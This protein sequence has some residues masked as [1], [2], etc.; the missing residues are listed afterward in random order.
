MR[1]TLALAAALVLGGCA[2]SAAAPRSA[3]LPSAEESV[4]LAEVPGFWT[5]EWGNLVLQPRG[6]EVWGAYTHRDGTLVGRFERGAI[7]GWWSE[8]P[9]REAS[10]D[11]GEVEIHFVRGADGLS[12]LGRYRH[13][14]QGPWI[15][16][17]NLRRSEVAPPPELE[18]RFAEPALFRSRP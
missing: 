12:L 5:G 16:V 18:A 17:W 2:G 15:Q 9:T 11:A 14:T 8:A 6:G 1:P 10:G 7:V 13:G 3:S 4:T